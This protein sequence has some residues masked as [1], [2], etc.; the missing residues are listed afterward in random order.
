VTADEPAARMPPLWVIK[1]RAPFFTVDVVPVCVG[2][3]VAW[4]R[5]GAFNLWYFVL[6]LLGTVCIN[7]GTNMTNDYFDHK[8][9]SDEVNTEFVDPFTGGSRLIQMGLV[10]PHTHLWQG[11]AFFVVG[12]SIGLLLALTRS[13]AILWIGIVG[14]FCG[15]FYTAPPFRLVRALVGELAVGICL[16]PLAAL[17]AYVVQTQQASWE[18]VIASLPVM[19][20]V[21][22]IL[23]INEFQ[24]APADA[25][26][27]KN[28]LVVR[29]G[30]RRAAVA[31][32]AL[33]AAAYVS[34]LAGVI[35]D[36]VTPFALL[37][38]LTMPQAIRAFRI[39][40]EHYDHPRELVPANIATIQL[41][42]RT[43]LLVALGYV[44]D[45]ALSCLL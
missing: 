2:T 37:G 5:S 19:I 16:G 11:I 23:W 8:W 15:F 40:R 34:L 39:A 13:E 41:H 25:S 44:L 35:L 42:L 9:G 33:L 6:A 17:G 20:L 32:G 27:G 28:H 3:A 31:Y 36:G 30:R 43:G 4:A 29:L 10:K 21:S 1:I 45:G 22:L 38:L 14:V 24:D 7:A 26:V 18:A 12:A